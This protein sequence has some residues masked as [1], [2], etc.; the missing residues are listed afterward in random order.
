MNQ[1]KYLF[2]ANNTISNYARLMGAKVC[3]TSLEPWVV[4]HLEVVKGD[5]KWEIKIYPHDCPEHVTLRY[6]LYVGEVLQHNEYYNS[7]IRNFIYSIL[8]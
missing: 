6:R 7:T 4:H 5:K 1:A 2:L 3:F 8:L